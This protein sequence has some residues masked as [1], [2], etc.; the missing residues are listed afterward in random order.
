[1]NPPSIFLPH[2]KHLS[3]PIMLLPPVVID[4]D[5]WFLIIEAYDQVLTE[6]LREVEELKPIHEV[7]VHIVILDGRLGEL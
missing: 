7:D 6:C 5:G 2:L 3:I 4:L 1:M